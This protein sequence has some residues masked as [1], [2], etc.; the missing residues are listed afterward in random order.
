M[1]LPT[2]TVKSSKVRNTGARIH[3]RGRHRK[4]AYASFIV[5]RAAPLSIEE[6]SPGII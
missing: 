6:N 4:P 3:G 5:D 2:P 1:L